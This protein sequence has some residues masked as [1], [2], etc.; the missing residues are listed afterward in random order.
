MTEHEQS[1]DLCSLLLQRGFDTV[2]PML[3][4]SHATGCLGEMSSSCISTAS[5]QDLRSFR[6]AIPFWQC[7]S[8]GL[9]TKT[10]QGQARSGDDF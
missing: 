10:L 9:D 6:L 7:T 3:I 5:S 2:C 4:A 8:A 1:W